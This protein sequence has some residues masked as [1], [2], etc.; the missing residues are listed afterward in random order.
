MGYLGRR[1]GLSQDKGDSTPGGADGAVGGGILDLFAS[2][3]FE[4][5]DKTFNAPSTEPSGHTA[6]GGIIGEWVDP[7]PGDVY[8]AHVF[9][10]SGTFDISQLGSFSSTVDLL[11]VGGGGGGSF[12]IPG[13]WAGNGG[14]AGGMIEVTGYP[15]GA[16][17]YPITVGAGGSGS[18]V[19]PGPQTKST[20]GTTG[21]DSSFNNPTSTPIH[22]VAK[23]GGAG[24]GSGPGVPGGEIRDNTGG[25]SCGGVGSAPG[26]SP[27]A[28]PAVSNSPLNPNVNALSGCTLAS[29]A[30]VGGQGQNGTAGEG[31]GGGGAGGNGTSATSPYSAQANNPGG[32]GRA[33]S[34][35]GTSIT[36]AAGGGAGPTAG[37]GANGTPGVGNGGGGGA[38]HPSG[39]QPGGTGGGGVVIVKY[40]IGTTA[41]SAKATGGNVSFYND[42]AIHAFT[43]S[44]TFTNTSG[45]DIT[46][47]TYVAIGGGGGGGGGAVSPNGQNAGGGGG[48]AGGYVTATGQTISTS[49]FPVSIGAGGGR[50]GGF[51]YSAQPGSDTVVAFPGGTITAGY[52]GGG[53][54]A[55]GGASGD[56]PL[57]S[58]GG[59]SGEG[60]DPGTSGP[61]GNNGG[62]SGNTSAGGGGGAGGAGD[63]GSTPGGGPGGAGVQLPTIFQDPTQASTQNIG[64]GGLGAPGPGGKKFYVAGGGGGGGYESGDVAGTGGYCPFPDIRYAGAGS[65]AYGT[66]PD[67]APVD[68]NNAIANTGSGGGGIWPRA[69]GGPQTNPDGS[70]GAGGSGLVL[71]AYPIS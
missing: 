58:G 47:V 8:R 61:Q 44:G 17:T 60:S 25:G 28:G 21:N 33:N 14:G 68:Y 67:Y 65:A 20:I 30:S 10:S 9:T 4:R 46:G 12:S 27:V 36:Y 40:K 35:T 64:A 6:S 16:N 42:N 29:Y 23:G 31:T 43:H 41:P 52:G 15:V 11:V 71:I 37:N 57:G 55:N 50:G 1:I 34:I 39:R 18:A 69:G 62:T 13:Y 51:E 19:A 70:G 53:G 66:H 22:V 45:S 3:Y 48:G 49:P 59:S 24:G 32:A 2:G 26:L 38:N 54:Y 56:A 7:S 5:Q 63:P